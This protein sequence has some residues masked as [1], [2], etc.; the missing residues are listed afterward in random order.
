MAIEAKNSVFEAI[1][2]L[3]QRS[4]VSE[5]VTFLQVRLPRNENVL[6]LTEKNVLSES[7]E[8]VVLTFGDMSFFTVKSHQPPCFRFQ[9]FP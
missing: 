3:I 5:V 8:L 4:F 7:S 1:S 2:E 9:C 6:S